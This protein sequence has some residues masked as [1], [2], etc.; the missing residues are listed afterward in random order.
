MP[1]NA[2]DAIDAVND[3][4]EDAKAQIA[5]LRAQVETLMR[6][7]VSPAVEDA[8]GR[9]EEAAHDAAET[10]RARAD[11]LAGR[12]RAQPLIAIGIAAAIGFLLGR[13]GR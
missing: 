8:A 7:R 5:R 11:A 2:K 1:T 10:L 4:A 3:T 6:E 9:L 12:V 13:L